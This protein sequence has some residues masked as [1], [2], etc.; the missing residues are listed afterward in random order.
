MTHPNLLGEPPATR[1]PDEPGPRE[2]LAAGADAAAVAAEHP[3]SCLAWAVLAETALAAGHAVEG[4][5]YARTGYHR[6]LDV[7]RRSGWK[8]AGPVPWEHEPNRGF[9]RSLHMLGV[10]ADA[11]GEDDEAERC[12]DFLRDSSPAAAEELGAK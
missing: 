5:A 9:L 2:A 1:L 4:Y 3:T 11:I 6:G 10:A 7:L 8:G 12:A